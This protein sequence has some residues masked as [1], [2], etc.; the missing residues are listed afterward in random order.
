MEQRSPLISAIIPVYNRPEQIRDAIDSVLNQTWRPLELIIGDDGSTD[1]TKTIVKDI[2]CSTEV[3]NIDYEIL[4]LSHTGMPGAVR[5]RCAEAAHGEVL[6]FL[7]SDDVWFPEKLAKQYSLHREHP[8]LMISHTRE[9]WN[10]AGRII[11]QSKLRHAREGYMFADS[12]KKCIIGPSTVMIRSGYYRRTG[13]FR[14]DLEIAEDYEFWLRIT[15]EQNVVYLDEPL[16]VKR[17]G[18]EGQLSEKYG[19]IEL[20]RIQGLKSL[21]DSEYFK[22]LQAS[23]AAEELAGK[24]RVYSKGC[25]KRGKAAEGRSFLELSEQ[26]LELSR[27]IAG[28]TNGIG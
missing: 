12:L 26:Y 9:E 4:E 8:E 11:S 27:K 21:V 7:D 22:G 3:G 5:N 25:L 13:G 24:C 10:R 15:S 1:N 17:A 18:H 19:H 28:D 6:A 2:L 16:T 23:L 20:F 14:E